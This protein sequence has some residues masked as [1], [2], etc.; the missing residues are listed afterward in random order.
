MGRLPSAIAVVAA[1]RASPHVRQPGPRRCRAEGSPNLWSCRTVLLDLFTGPV[2]DMT[3]E[4]L[5]TSLVVVATPGTGVPYTVA[6][7]SLEAPAPA[8][9]RRLAA[10][11]G[12]SAHDRGDHRRGCAAEGPGAVGQRF[13][14]G[15]C[16]ATFRNG[17]S[18]QGNQP[19]GHRTS[20]QG[21][22][23]RSHTVRRPACSSGLVA[24][25]P[26]SATVRSRWA[27]E[28]SGWQRTSSR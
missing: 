22:G 18:R 8:W 6:A 1:R 21:P 17:E 12:S 28:P 4:L 24:N 15:P 2:D 9:W 20:Q 11:S 27:K 23:G 26:E 7:D 14:P 16:S 5:L 19:N 3:V 10:R 13:A 25:R